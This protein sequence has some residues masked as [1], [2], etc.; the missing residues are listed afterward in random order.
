MEAPNAVSAVGGFHD[1]VPDRFKDRAKETT[2]RFFIIN[3][4]D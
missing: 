4:E 2:H 1:G 3:D